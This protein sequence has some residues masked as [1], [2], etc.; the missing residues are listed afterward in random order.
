MSTPQPKGLKRVLVAR[1][2]EIAG[3]VLRTCRERGVE[4]GAGDGDVGRLAPRVQVAD[5][6]VAIGAAPASQSSLVI[7]KIIDACRKSGAD[8]VHPGYGFLSENE[9]FA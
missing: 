9:D 4:A 5:F 2:G 6:A 8:A 1:R 7:D 3:R